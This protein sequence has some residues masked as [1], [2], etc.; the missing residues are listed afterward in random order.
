M[1]S[2]F[3]INYNDIQQR[4]RKG[5]TVVRVSVQVDAVEAE[6]A[7]TSQQAAG[8]GA[9]RSAKAKAR[10]IKEYDGMTGEIIV[11]HED[12]IGDA[13]WSQRPWLLS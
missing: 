6:P 8:G 12:I 5:S 13:F 11:V 7:V 2:R 1:Y 10:R 3:G 9:E 4:F